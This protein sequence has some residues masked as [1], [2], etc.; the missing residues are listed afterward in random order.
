MTCEL[1]CGKNCKYKVFLL[2]EA[3]HSINIMKLAMWN[4][5]SLCI[6]YVKCETLC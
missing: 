5:T 4:D 3:K 2:S 6:T 1:T